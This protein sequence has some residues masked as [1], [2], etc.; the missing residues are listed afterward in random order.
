MIPTYICTYTYMYVI[1][2]SDSKQ[3]VDLTEEKKE[4]DSPK[5]AAPSSWF[6]FWGCDTTMRIN[7]LYCA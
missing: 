3:G 6:S 5:P 4:G 1:A 7:A 2:V